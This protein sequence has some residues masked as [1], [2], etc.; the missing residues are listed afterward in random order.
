MPYFHLSTGLRG[1]YEAST[2]S[3]IFARTRRELKEA[4]AYEANLYRDSGYVGANKR[5]IAAH[6]AEVWRRRK[7][8]RFSLPLALPVAPPHAPTNYCEAVFVS[9]ATRRDYSDFQKE[10]DQ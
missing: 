5:A 3:V 1:C 7:D 8:K 10:C 4:I 2:Q 9:P 6:A